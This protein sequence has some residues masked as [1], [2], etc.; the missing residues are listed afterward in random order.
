MKW[1]IVIFIISMLLTNN[2]LPVIAQTN[3]LGLDT[4]LLSSVAGKTFSGVDYLAINSEFVEES[5]SMGLVGSLF[6]VYK[7]Y[8]SSQDSQ[9]CSFHPSCSEY[10]VLV[11]QH[12]GKFKGLLETLDRLSRCHGLAP[13]QYAVDHQTGLLIDPVH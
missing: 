3:N 8:V 11:V 6:Y 9:S 7:K 2:L 5:K 4:N 10:A 1:P 13:H 12:K